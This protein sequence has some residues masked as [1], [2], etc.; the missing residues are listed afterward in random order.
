MHRQAL[1]PPLLMGE[2]AALVWGLPLPRV[3]ARTHVAQVTRPGDSSAADVARHV[4]HVPPEQRTVHHG[5]HVTTLERTA[6]DCAAA[7]DPYAG[8]VVADAALHVGAD[9]E[10]ILAMVARA[11]GHRGVRRARAVVEAADAGAESPGETWLRWTMLRFGLPQPTTQVPVQ[12]PAGCYWA[13]LGYPAW[14]VLV[15]Y[16]GAEKYGADG[17]QAVAA[18]RKERRRQLAVEE[19]GWRVVRVTAADRRDP[20]ALVARLRAALPDHQSTPR[21]YLQPTTRR[22][23]PGARQPA[24]P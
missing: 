22:R 3:P 10:A 17:A 14:R 6:F 19:A 23:R 5:L 16:D 15:E 11:G 24:R 8:L 7:L 13:D 2:S 18:L 9:R 12:T 4:V 1:H 20:P 21:P